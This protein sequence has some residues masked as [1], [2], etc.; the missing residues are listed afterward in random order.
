MNV[1][2]TATGLGLLAA[3][4]GGAWLYAA[5]VPLGLG[6]GAV[7]AGLNGFVARHYE[8]K[9][10]NLLHAC[11]GIGATT[12]PML[13]GLMLGS[14]AGWRGGYAALSGIQPGLVLLFLVRRR[15]LRGD[16][17]RSDRGRLRGQ[18]CPRAVPWLV[19]GVLVALFGG[20][21]LLDRMT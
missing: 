8:G 7:D 21:R 13:F 14:A 15:L 4:Q 20:I 17:A 1:L 10:M 3:A 9:H 2:L 5:A 12:G 18:P 19:L 11:W 6:A 16:H